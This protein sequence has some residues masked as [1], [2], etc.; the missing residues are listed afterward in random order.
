MR[1]VLDRGVQAV[2]RGGARCALHVLGRSAK[3]D[4]CGRSF[5]VLLT[6]V[7]TAGLRLRHNKLACG[8]ML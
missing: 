4:A 8:G 2:V 3:V 7:S 1:K 5:A 6:Q